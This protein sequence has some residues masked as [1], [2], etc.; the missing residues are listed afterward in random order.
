MR[1][2]GGMGVSRT[3]QRWLAATAAVTVGFGLAAVALADDDEDDGGQVAHAR[4]ADRDGQPVG[5]VTFR[6]RPG[7]VV[8][9]G[10][11][12]GVA[13]GFHGFHVHAVG[14]CDPDAVDATGQPSPFSSAGGHLNP[15]G[16]EH[17]GHAG[18]LP[19]LLVNGDG[20]AFARFATDRFD[21]ATLFDAD[22]SAVIIHAQPDNFAHIPTRYQSSESPEP[23]ADAATRQ[24]GDSGDRYACG[25]IERR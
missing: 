8:V 20:T 25:V 6:E 22:G 21:L 23:G 4:L 24:T 3:A 14:V 12:A 13:P 16:M 5:R 7:V 2:T 1:F 19:S 15:T 17:G 18:D 11:V 9:S 10:R